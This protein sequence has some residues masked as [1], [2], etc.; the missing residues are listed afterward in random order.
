VP[1]VLAD[2]QSYNAIYGVTNNPWELE[3]HPGDRREAPRGSA[4]V[5]YRSSL[6]SDLVG[7][8]ESLRIFAASSLTSRPMASSDARLRAARDALP[9]CRPAIDLAVVGRWLRS[10]GDLAS[11]LDVLAGPLMML[12][13]SA[14]NL[15]SR[16]SRH[17]ESEE[18]PRARA[19]YTSDGPDREQCPLGARK[20][21]D[22]LSSLEQSR[23]ASP[24]FLI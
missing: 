7:S 22:R 15:A 16:Q 1:F 11:A 20:I 12:T 18:F 6:D 3:A 8:C 21:A 24:S 13:Q 19:G 23:P 14:Y 17:N 4:A 9:Q 10:P 5:M 2:W